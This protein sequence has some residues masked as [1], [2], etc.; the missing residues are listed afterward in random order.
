[1]RCDE[2]VEILPEMIDASGPV[3]PVVERHV[4]SC[5]RCQAEVAKY[6]KLL[7]ALHTLRSYYLEPAPGVLSQTLAA[8]E[9]A[10]ERRAIR[11]VLAGH[12]VAAGALGGVA[13]AAGAA[14]TTAVI[15]A[16]SRRRGMRLAG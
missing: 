5:L 3:D 11:S 9:A 16:R 13:V 4:V 1:M 15:I 14:A 7:R 10:G 8:L 6:H 12:R 2:V